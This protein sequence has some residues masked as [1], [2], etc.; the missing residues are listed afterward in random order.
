MKA[1]N[2]AKLAMLLTPFVFGGGSVM[3]SQNGDQYAY[4]MVTGS[5]IPQ[6]IKIHSIGTKSA[7]PL[8]VYDRREIEQTGRVTTE[9][10]LAEDPALTVIRGQPGGSR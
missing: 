8:R 9:G 6:K 5:L 10:V 7:F 1:L 3:A 4:V 2:L